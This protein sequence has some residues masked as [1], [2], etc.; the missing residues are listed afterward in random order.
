LGS[1]R[2]ITSHTGA[3]V[4]EKSYDGFG[5]IKSETSPTNGDPRGYTGWIFMAENGP[6]D[7]RLGFIDPPKGKFTGRDPMGLTPDWNPYVYAGNNPTNVTDPSGLQSIAPP[8]PATYWPTWLQWVA[9]APTSLNVVMG[10]R[11]TWSNQRGN[12]T[13]TLSYPG[14]SEWTVA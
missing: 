7:R 14:Y 9:G 2:V 5:N 10:E 11:G 13:E 6:G 12:T 8:H 3:V 1:I 4:D